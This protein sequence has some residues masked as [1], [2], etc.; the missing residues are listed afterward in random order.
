MLSDP[1]VAPE[2][3]A[4]ELQTEWF[5]DCD[6]LYISGYALLRSPIELA[7]ARLR[8][9]A[10]KQIAERLKQR[11]KL[12]V[13]ANRDDRHASLEAAID[14]S[15]ELL[16]PWEQACFAQASVFEGGFTLHAAE[17][18]VDLSPLPE[19]PWVLDVVQALADKSLV[20]VKGTDEGQEP[21]FQMYVTLQEYGRGK[22][23]A[24]A[25]RAAEERHGRHFAFF[26]RGQRRFNAAEQ[27]RP[28]KQISRR[29]RTRPRIHQGTGKTLRL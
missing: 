3:R 23:D 9:M 1:G 20:R 16:K 8:V 27:Y 7:A 15:W 22:L 10:P 25:G 14:A 5:Q 13:D 4:E 26:R 21:R 12:L 18:V 19:A 28:D 11:F 29:A 2:L 24:D 17:A 6:A